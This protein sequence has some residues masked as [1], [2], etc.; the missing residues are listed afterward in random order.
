LRVIS[1]ATLRDYWNAHP[2]TKELLSSWFKNAEQA[3]W[4]GHNDIRNTYR[5]ADPVGGEYVV[6]NI[7]FNEYRLVVKADYDRGIVYIWDVYTHKEYDKIDF[8]SLVKEDERRKKAL[9]KPK[10]GT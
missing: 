5:T 6:F 2:K 7:L 9:S 8:D 1:R 3:V 4:N 10:K